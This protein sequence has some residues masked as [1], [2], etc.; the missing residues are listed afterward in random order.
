MKLLILGGTDEYIGISTV[1]CNKAFAADLTFR[2]PRETVRDT[3]AWKTASPSSDEMRS[4][5]KPGQEKELLA[6]WHSRKE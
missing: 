2:S 5:L 4:G 1:N 3:L 6:K